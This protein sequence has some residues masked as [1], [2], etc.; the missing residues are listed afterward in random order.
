MVTKTVVSTGKHAVKAAR[1]GANLVVKTAESTGKHIATATKTTVVGLSTTTKKKVVVKKKDGDVGDDDDDDEEY[2]YPT[3]KSDT[4]EDPES[5]SSSKTAEPK[6]HL[7]PAVKAAKHLVHKVSDV[8]NS[9]TKK[10]KRKEASSETSSTTMLEESSSTTKSTTK[11]SGD[12][13]PVTGSSKSMDTTTTSSLTAL[14]EPT[15]TVVLKDETIV[16]IVVASIVLS[17]MVDHWRE[18]L[19]NQF[20]AS[21]VLAWMLVAFCVG[22]KMDPEIWSDFLETKVMGITKVSEAASAAA[23][24]VPHYVLDPTMPSSQVRQHRL[25]FLQSLMRQRQSTK[26][27]RLPVAFTNLNR[28]RKLRDSSQK[29]VSKFTIDRN[30]MKR[31]PMFRRKGRSPSAPEEITTI[32]TTPVSSSSSIKPM[33]PMSSKV[34]LGTF[35]LKDT[36]ADSLVDQVTDPLCELRGMDLFL[37]ECAEEKM[38]THPFLLK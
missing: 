29:Q 36:N 32:T 34:M 19:A 10:M 38:T 16:W 27:P 11:A 12:E 17:S 25:G 24:D 35:D 13:T 8:K 15:E 3:K 26:L 22:Q 1:E 23:A 5:E 30:L 2:T 4:K 33:S 6:L 37:T 14:L 9:M 18:I 21:V 20:P 7:N 28:G 31:L